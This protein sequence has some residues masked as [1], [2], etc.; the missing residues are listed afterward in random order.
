MVPIPSLEAVTDVS[1]VSN[2]GKVTTPELSENSVNPKL[3]TVAPSIDWPPKSVIEIS[4]SINLWESTM[5]TLVE[6]EPPQ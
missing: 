2:T 1:P 4:A 3:S 5:F 6:L